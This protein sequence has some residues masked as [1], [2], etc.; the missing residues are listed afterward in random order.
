ML[1]KPKPKEL[2]FGTFADDKGQRF[3][4]R[5]GSAN[6]HRIGLNRF[7]IADTFHSL[8]ISRWPQFLLIIIS[9]YVIAN[10]IFATI[11]FLIGV[12]QI[13]V[14]KTDAVSDWLEAFFFSTQCITTVGFGRVNPQG[15]A[16]NIVSSVESLTGLLTFALAT[17]LLYG[18][19]SRPQSQLVKSDNLVI[20]PYGEITGAMFRIA[21]KRK[22]SL[23]LENFVSVSL[24]INMK[25]NGTLRRR[26][27]LLSLELERINYLTSSWT[28]VHPI[29]EESPL[30]GLTD[31]D[32]V[33]GRAE[34]IILY[35]ATDET[36]SQSVFE[37]FSYF[38]NEI[39]FNAKFISAIGTTSEG[40]PFLDLNKIS[41]YELLS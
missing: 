11:Y 38:G 32:L 31:E 20:A 41:D 2:G 13:G 23:L 1:R 37:R 34:F 25:E 9:Y 30:F 40:Q 6:F 22:K 27:Y 21:S 5:D 12:E 7:S 14:V 35:K 19:F 36:T 26:F 15:M 16:A 33:N 4:N 39:V 17:G 29:N 8:I 24:G 3:L 18:R 28:L 10:A